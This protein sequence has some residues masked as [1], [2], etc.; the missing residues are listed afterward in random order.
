ML[1]LGLAVFISLPLGFLAF[2]P[3]PAR[4][5]EMA[6]RA[7]AAQ[8]EKDEARREALGVSAPGRELTQEELQARDGGTT[9]VLPNRVRVE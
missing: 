5:L 3:D 6:Q 8:R 9:I 7:L 2:G 4:Q 1:A